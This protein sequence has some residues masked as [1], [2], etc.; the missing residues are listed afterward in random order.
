MHRKDIHRIQSSD[1]T[2]APLNHTSWP[3]SPCRTNLLQYFIQS[4]ARP[5][6][7]RCCSLVVKACWW[8]ARWHGSAL[9][10]DAAPI[11]LVLCDPCLCIGSPVCKLPKSC[12]QDLVLRSGT[13]QSAMHVYTPEHIPSLAHP[14]RFESKACMCVCTVRSSRCGAGA[15]SKLRMRTKHISSKAVTGMQRC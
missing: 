14:V 13:A 7:L 11:G 12:K 5:F 3:S 6:T 15:D 9:L 4:S 8:H 10:L 1:R 2:P